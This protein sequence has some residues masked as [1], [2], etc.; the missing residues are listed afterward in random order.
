[1]VVYCLKYEIFENKQ[2]LVHLFVLFLC[3]RNMKLSVYSCLVT[4][5]GQNH[6]IKIANRCF[7]NVTHLKY[8]ATAVTNQNFI[9][10]EIKRILNSGNASYL[11][12]QNLLSSRLRS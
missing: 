10:E 9:Q 1:M 8:L 2:H 7:E 6:D 12:D 11:S 3:T 4:R 5:I